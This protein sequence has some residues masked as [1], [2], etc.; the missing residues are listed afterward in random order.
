MTMTKVAGAKLPP[1]LKLPKTLGAVIDL[2][3]TMQQKREVVEATVSAMKEQEAAVEEYL[4]ANFNEETLSGARGKVGQAS[5]KPS[6]VPEIKDW[7]KL[8]AYISRTK[9]WDILQRR[10]SVTALRGRWDANKVVPGVE[11]KTIYKLS[12]KKV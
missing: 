10:L 7:D 6:V 8:Y 2:L 12:I 3:F 4:R 9:G 1:P 11:S 5:L